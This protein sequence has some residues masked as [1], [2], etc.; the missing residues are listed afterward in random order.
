[1]NILYISS[2]NGQRSAGLTY[3]VPAQISSQKKYDK[4]FW[5]NINS[6]KKELISDLPELKNV[7]D[8]PSIHI[9]DL[10]NPFN[11]PDIVI[12]EGVYFLRYL[13]ISKE[14]KKRN[15][16]Y[17]IVPRSSLT[18]Y[19]QKKKYLKKLI[20]N[21]LFFKS[22]IRRAK[23]IHYLTD[24]ELEDSGLKWNKKNIIIPNGIE[25]KEIVKNYKKKDELIGVY[26]GRP[27]SY[28]KGIDL[29]LDA[30][31][32][33][34]DKLLNSNCKIE[35]YA[36][37]LKKDNSDIDKMIYQRKLTDIVVSKDGVYGK[38]KEKVLLNSDFFILT[39]RFE[40]HP[41]GLIEALSYGIPALVTTGTNMGKLISEYDSGWVADI[42]VDSIAEKLNCLLNEV[43]KIPFKGKNAL[44]LSYKFEWNFIAKNT[45]SELKNILNK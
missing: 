3:S 25:P 34:K 27:E 5:Y 36:P 20:A 8:Y 32:K 26:I 9:C 14:C 13:F 1:M 2:L 22:F 11:N 16:P 31:V 39:S 37:K 23:A 29:L 12:F 35:I 30:C 44:N 7:N 4:V 18:A 15:I 45:H 40:G 33:V 42:K 6:T 10:P 24:R 19:A 41:M 43:D 38:D 17:V 28:Q 21:W